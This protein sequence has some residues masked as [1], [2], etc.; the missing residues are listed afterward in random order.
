MAALV[1][2]EKDFELHCCSHLNVPGHIISLTGRRLHFL[3]L[4][5]S[6]H[7]SVA[8]LDCFRHQ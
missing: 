6:A 8:S 7:I 1:A 4:R 3:L 5:R 2:C